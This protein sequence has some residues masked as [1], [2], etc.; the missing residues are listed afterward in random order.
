LGFRRSRIKWSTT[1]CAR[2]SKPS[3]SRTFEAA[4]RGFGR[5][6]VPT[7][8]CVPWSRW[9][10]RARGGG[11]SRPTSYPSSTAWIAPR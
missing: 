1:P 11:S 10:T 2:Y 3:T 9:C 8:P 6:A 4:R 7:P 5:G